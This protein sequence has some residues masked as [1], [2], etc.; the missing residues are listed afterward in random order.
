M[1]AT[2]AMKQSDELLSGLIAGLTAEHRELRTPCDQWNV[3][4]LVDHICS[5]T[6][7]IAGG[8][9]GEAPPDEQPDFMAEGPANAWREAAA[10]LSAVATPEVLNS[11]HEMPFGH[12]PG[13]AAVGL[14][15]AD[16]V[17]HA[18]DLAKATDQ[19]YS[20]SDELAQFALNTWHGFAPAEGRT[21]DAFKPA[22]EISDDAP[23]VDRLAAYTGRQP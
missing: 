22:I 2:A 8:L 3:H 13:E 15:V 4:E 5:G 21:G 6:H 11:L 23:L 20:P 1:D 10:H 7:G 9:A 16:Q 19:P 12:V 14:I 17:T 18:W